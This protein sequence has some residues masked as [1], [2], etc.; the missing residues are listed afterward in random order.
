MS[1]KT[2]INQIIKVEMIFSFDNDPQQTG[3]AFITAEILD[4]KKE[5]F[6]W[7]TSCL[8]N[9]EKQ[10]LVKLSCSIQNA[11]IPT[12]DHWYLVS[13]GKFWDDEIPQLMKELWK[14]ESTITPIN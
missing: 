5:F 1:Q 13:N 10:T 6:K 12:P 14:V 9:D 7:V 11:S 3:S 4:N 2:L 8:E